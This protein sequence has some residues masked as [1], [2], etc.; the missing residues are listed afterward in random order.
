MS[1]GSVV[2]VAAKADDEDIWVCRRCGWTYPNHHPS[3]RHRRNHRK[4]CGKVK[5]FEVVK[6]P[7][8]LDHGSSDDVSSGEEKSVHQ[9]QVSEAAGGVTAPAVAP[10]T[11]QT[12]AE[13]G[14]EDKTPSSTVGLTGE[15]IPAQDEAASH[16][17][18]DAP[19]SS[20]EPSDL[21]EQLLD[22]QVAGTPPSRLEA[23]HANTENSSIEEA[24]ASHKDEFGGEDVPLNPF[25]PPSPVVHHEGIHVAESGQLEEIPIHSE[26]NPFLHP[27][28]PV[29]G[30]QRVDKEKAEAS[31]STSWDSIKPHVALKSLFDEDRTRQADRY[32]LEEGQAPV[33]DVPPP[34]RTNSNVLMKAIENVRNPLAKV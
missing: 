32:Y 7:E 34:K 24:S 13:G 21:W 15:L 1:N 2:P 27:D 22:A 9:R 3:A 18:Q 23:A 8:Q 16:P 4:H 6:Q 12:V 14:V 17:E 29:S 5:G 28:S 11:H 31:S 25:V 20:D 26:K 30:T 33:P 10:E 19:A